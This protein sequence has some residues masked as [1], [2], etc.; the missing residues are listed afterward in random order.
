MRAKKD[1]EVRCFLGLIG[2]VVVF[3]PFSCFFFSPFLDLFFVSM[4]FLV[5][6]LFSPLFSTVGFLGG[7]GLRGYWKGTGVAFSR[8]N[9]NF[10]ALYSISN[11]YHLS[12]SLPQEQTPEMTSLCA[13]NLS[14]SPLAPSMQQ[15]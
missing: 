7:R 1:G 10:T 14:D 9:K 6:W 8:D 15:T 13:R 2:E 4:L 5:D 3:S 12:P 11:N